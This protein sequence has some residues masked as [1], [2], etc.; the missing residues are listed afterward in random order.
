MKRVWSFLLVAVLALSLC[1]CRATKEDLKIYVVPGEK[2]TRTMG[3]EAI[4]DVAR[5]SGRIAFTGQD[6]AGWLWEEHRVQLKDISVTGK[7][8]DGGSALFQA[9]PNDLFVLVLGGRTVYVGGFA[10]ATGA[11]KAAR[12]PYIQDGADDTFYLKIDR[13]NAEGRDPRADAKLYDYLAEQQLLVS[14]IQPL[15][16]AE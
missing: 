7:A 9:G 10:P 3:D 1:A 6:I 4:L 12:S 2:V 8:G 11:V 16:E 5:K 15:G 13:K 14:A